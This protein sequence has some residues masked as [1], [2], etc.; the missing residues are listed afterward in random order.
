MAA[1]KEQAAKASADD[2]SRLATLQDR[3]DGREAAALDR[4]S[5]ANETLQST[6]GDGS[7]R[8]IKYLEIAAGK[9]EAATRLLD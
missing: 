4:I 9:L 5:E 1:K 2:A 8:Y 6:D 3:T 7:G